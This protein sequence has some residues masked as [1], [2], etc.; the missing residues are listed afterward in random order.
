[1]RRRVVITGMGAITPLGHSV[2][3]MIEAQLA[4]RSGVGPISHFNAGRFPTTFASEVK[5]YDL[6]R[7]VPDAGA[8]SR[9]CGLN[10]R[11]AGGAAQQALKDAGLLDDERM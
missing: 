9:N 7:F 1:M 4:G 3:D 10:S 2:N 5:D 6:A 11:F 8:W